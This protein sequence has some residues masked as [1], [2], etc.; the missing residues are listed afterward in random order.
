MRTGWQRGWVRGVTTIL[1]LGMLVLIFFFSAEDASRS[2]RTSGAVSEWVAERTVPE[3]RQMAPAK[4]QTV[5]DQIQH[6]VRKNAHFLEYTLLGFLLRCCLESWFT[7]RKRLPLWA[8]M[9]GTLY[10]AT[11]EAHQLLVDGRGGSV[12]DVLL[13]SS[14]VLCGVLLGMLLVSRIRKRKRAKVHG[15]EHRADLS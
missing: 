3:F 6:R 11:D 10:A 4:K 13:D 14:G 12:L 2:N 7:G 5:V 1:T 8:W 15:D 9:G